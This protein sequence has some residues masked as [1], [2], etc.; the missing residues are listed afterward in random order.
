MRPFF[1]GLLGKE[2]KDGKNL[3][4]ISIAEDLR[5]P[6]KIKVLSDDKEIL[7]L[8]NLSTKGTVYYDSSAGL[9]VE[10]NS[11]SEMKFGSDTYDGKPIK[12]NKGILI[13]SVNTTKLVPAD[14]KAEQSK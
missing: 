12:K 9:M 11:Q 5:S 7:E 13:T 10:Y 8:R 4:K 2:N 14:S 3:D 6:C 1:N